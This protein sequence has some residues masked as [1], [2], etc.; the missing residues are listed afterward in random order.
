M[1]ALIVDT[2]VAVVFFTTFATLTERLVVGLTWEQIA[3]TRL[4]T[5]P[6]MLL[7]GRPY[8]LWR[9]AIFRRLRPDRRVAVAAVDTLAFV[10]FQA[11][12]YA[13]I[14]AFAG[15]TP[16]QMAA[17]LASAV[18]AMLVLGRPYGLVLAAARR[19]AGTSP[20]P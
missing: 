10:S 19:L 4:G 11:P 16:G 15:A 13:V 17:A 5:I 18:A 6:V 7:T 8:G 9:D 1:R 20:A 3:T 2:L 14:L 12:V